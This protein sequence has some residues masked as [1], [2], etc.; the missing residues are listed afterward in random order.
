LAPY[1]SEV[2]MFPTARDCGYLLDVHTLLY[3]QKLEEAATTSNP[4]LCL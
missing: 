2:R 3:G 4:L 1:K